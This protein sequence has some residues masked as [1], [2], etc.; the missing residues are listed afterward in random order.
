MAAIYFISFSI[1]FWEEKNKMEFE[2]NT[3]FPKVKI[4]KETNN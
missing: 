1:L 4:M 3:N 2:F